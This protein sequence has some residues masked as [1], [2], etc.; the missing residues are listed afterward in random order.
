MKKKTFLIDID[1]TICKNIGNK[2]KEA[3]PYK[4]KILLIN[5]LYEKRHTIKFFTSRFMGRNK[6]SSSRAKKQGFIMTSRQL[7][8]WKCK[9]HFLFFGKPS[10]DISIDDKSINYK[11]KW[12]KNLKKYL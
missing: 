8:K 4:K 10:H 11:N 6:E 3:K 1:N 7:K 12:E 2:Y 5:K 9:Y